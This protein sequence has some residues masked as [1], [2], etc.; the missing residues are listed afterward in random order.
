MQDIAEKVKERIKNAK[1][2]YGLKYSMLARQ[3][4]VQST[5]LYMFLSGKQALSKAKQLQALYV[6]E[7][8]QKEF[9]RRFKNILEEVMQ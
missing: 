7:E 4:E 1:V 3:I 5:T 6:V 2:M 9:E 8:Y